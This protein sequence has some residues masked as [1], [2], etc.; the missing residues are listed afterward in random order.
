MLLTGWRGFCWTLPLVCSSSCPPA[1][2][3]GRRAAGPCTART[4]AG[5]APTAAAG[6]LAPQTARSAARRRKQRQAGKV[7]PEALG[8][9][10]KAAPE[11]LILTLICRPFFRCTKGQESLVRVRASQ[12]TR[13]LNS[14]NVYAERKSDGPV[15]IHLGLIY[16]HIITHDFR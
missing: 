11:F 13:V 8:S 16:C 12:V 7:S 4:A 14:L 2:C 1:R 5:A 10:A 15:L 9:D 6:R 3:R